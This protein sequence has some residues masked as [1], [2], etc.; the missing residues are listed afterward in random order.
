MQAGGGY[1]LTCVIK[2]YFINFVIKHFKRVRNF[3]VGGLES[4][5]AL[6]YLVFAHLT[7]IK[8]P[9]NI[10]YTH[11]NSVFLFI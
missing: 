9:K 5:S 1:V 2:M 3:E 11:F 6:G 4:H 7:E 10:K 8:Q